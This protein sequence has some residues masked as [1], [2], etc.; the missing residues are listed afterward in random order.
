MAQVNSNKMNKIYRF[1]YC[2]ETGKWLM[3]VTSPGW[4]GYRHNGKSDLIYFMGLYALITGDVEVIKACIKLLNEGN[5]WPDSLN[6]PFDAKNKIEQYISRWKYKISKLLFPNRIIYVKYRPQ[7][8]V[9]RDVFTT[10]FAAIY[11]HQYEM[12]R[13]LKV[14]WRL[15]TPSFFHWVQYLKTHKPIHKLKYEDWE[16][17]G[18]NVASI[19]GYPG[20]VK[21]LDSWK[22]WIVKSDIKEELI[23]HIPP[24]NL[25]CRM[26]CGERVDWEDIILYQGSTGYL[27]QADKPKDNP[28]ICTEH[29]PFQMDEEVLRF[30]Y[31]NRN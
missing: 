12:I 20:Y 17:F 26:L 28:T 5:R 10:V 29:E 22:A 16:R 21:H 6:T 27:W 13:D 11:F 25:L 30:V 8:S 19:F 24:W 2:D 14:P 23:K 18:I 4:F 7:S 3:H 1:W 31:E 15:Y 9:T